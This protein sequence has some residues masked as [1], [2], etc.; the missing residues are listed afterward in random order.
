MVVEHTISGVKRLI[1]IKDTLRIH[2]SDFRDSVMLAACSLHNFRTLF[3]AWL[4][5]EYA[6]LF[7]LSA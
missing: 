3:R 6:M 5:C 4:A 7:L 1:I 2:G